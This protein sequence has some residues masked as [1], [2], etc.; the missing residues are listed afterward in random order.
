MKFL[1]KKFRR[2]LEFDILGMIEFEEWKLIRD[3]KNRS[4]VLD[5]AENY[6]PDQAWTE[7]K[8][9][10]FQLKLIQPVPQSRLLIF[11]ENQ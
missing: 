10:I 6:P 11:E 5:I 4:K 8:N 7:I 3:T 1:T 2:R 9:L